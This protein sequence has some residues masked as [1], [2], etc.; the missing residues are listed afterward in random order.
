MSTW[1]PQPTQP[2]PPPVSG[3]GPVMGPPTPSSSNNTP[4]VIG[5]VVLLV[6]VIGAAGVFLL[7]GDDDSGNSENASNRREREEQEEPQDCAGSDTQ[8]VDGTDSGQAQAEED[9]DSCVPPPNVE[10]PTP[11][12]D[13]PT[14]TEVV[15][16]EVPSGDVLDALASNVYSNTPASIDEDTAYC[17]AEVIVDVVGESTVAAADADYQTVYGGTSVEEDALIS[18]GAYSCTT[19][20]QD[21]DLH[22]SSNWPDP[23]GPGEVT[24]APSGDVLDSLASNVYG[25]TP[26]SI[27]ED[28]AYCLAEVI[29]SVVGE[30]AVAA[31][32]ADYQS[33]YSASS[34]DQDEAI[35]QGAYSCTT[36]EQD[37]DLYA[38]SAWPDAWD[39]AP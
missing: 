28:T 23:W 9:G 13:E 37:A 17:L 12:T 29:T 1:P 14:E 18:S 34:P 30:S 11:T 26:A 5:L 33:V 2:G 25:N 38:S 7:S 6:A 19:S 15:V 8:S 22:A 27:D 10:V 3:P 21:A 24:S 16:E 31:A 36:S 39:P 20:E 32:G 35:S 4:L